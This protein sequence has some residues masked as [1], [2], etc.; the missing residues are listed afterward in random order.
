MSEPKDTAFTVPSVNWCHM[1]ARELE[2]ALRGAG[3]IEQ[4]QFQGLYEKAVE[5]VDVSTMQEKPKDWAFLKLAEFAHDQLGVREVGVVVQALHFAA[6]AR[7]SSDQLLAG[8]F[9]SLSA[10][11]PSKE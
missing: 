5:L 8:L 11:T 3:Q 9:V 4:A 10:K 1:V 6:A 7:V 2:A